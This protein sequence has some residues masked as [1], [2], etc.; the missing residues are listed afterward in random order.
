[1]EPNPGVITVWW[2]PCMEPIDNKQTKK[3]SIIKLLNFQIQTI[4]YIYNNIITK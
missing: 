3:M 1:M 2:E 4:S